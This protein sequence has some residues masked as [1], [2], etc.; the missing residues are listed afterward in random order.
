MALQLQIRLV[1]VNFL[2][3]LEWELQ[4][5]YRPAFIGTR[6][7]ETPRD[8]FA[9]R[10][11]TKLAMSENSNTL[12]FAGMARQYNLQPTY[13]PNFQTEKVQS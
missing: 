10:A 8:R 2:P 7:F 4:R 9:R 6:N 12:A 5:A 3:E 1:A 11:A 13:A